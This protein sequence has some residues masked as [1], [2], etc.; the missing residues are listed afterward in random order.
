MIEAFRDPRIIKAEIARQGRRRPA[1]IVRRE[2]PQAKQRADAGRLHLALVLGAAQRG[3][4]HLAVHRHIAERA[5]EDVLLLVA[6]QRFPNDLDRQIGQRLLDHAPLLDPL[7]R[8]V[9]AR[10]VAVEVEQLVAVRGQQFARAQHGD[11]LELE[12][13]AGLAIPRQVVAVEAVP[14]NPDLVLGQDPRARMLRVELRQV[15]AGAGGHIVAARFRRPVEQARGR[16][17]HVAGIGDRGNAELACHDVVRERC[18]VVLGDFA[19]DLLAEPGAEEAPQMAGD[20]LPAFDPGP[21]FAVRL[22]DR[23]LHPLDP[24]LDDLVD[25]L[26]SLGLL[27]FPVAEGFGERRSA[28]APQA[29]D[30]AAG[31]LD[32]EGLGVVDAQP[33]GALL[34]GLPD[35]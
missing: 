18:D 19:R 35:R 21:H 4:H 22:A 29:V 13:E 2:R 15:D 34:A 27:H 28:C 11:Q 1:Q 5:G 16:A 31:V 23:R 30:P 14:E 25:G 3:R 6:G 9:K 17:P 33:A 26:A 12:R 10:I 8:D 7:Q 24:L 32:G 20:V